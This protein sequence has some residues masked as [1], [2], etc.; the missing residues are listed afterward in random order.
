M[1]DTASQPTHTEVLAKITRA[2]GTV[3]DLG[4]IATSNPDGPGTVTV[5]EPEEHKSDGR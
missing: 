5:H 4:V 3:E 2:D 1:T